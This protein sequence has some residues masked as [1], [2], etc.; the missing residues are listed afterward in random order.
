MYN[1]NQ[2]NLN[3]FNFPASD[4]NTRST[5]NPF[6]PDT[7]PTREM[8]IRV[9]NPEISSNMRQIFTFS[10]ANMF[11][12][13]LS[14][15]NT[16]Q[17]AVNPVPGT[18]DVYYFNANQGLKI[19]N[20]LN[21]P[22]VEIYGTVNT[23]LSQTNKEL[24]DIFDPI[25]SVLRTILPEN[26]TVLLYKYLKTEIQ[27]AFVNLIDTEYEAWIN[28]LNQTSFKASYTY[29]F[30]F[31]FS[32]PLTSETLIS[33]PVGLT[34]E[35]TSQGAQKDKTL[36][37]SPLSYVDCNVRIQALAISQEIIETDGLPLSV[38]SALT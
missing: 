11:A 26:T 25:V 24:R 14:I 23:T 19:V 5:N 31:I 6:L 33:M 35:L 36:V 7:D 13:G 27:N 2:V 10:D 16:F 28:F 9:E 29:N 34:I 1:R 12:Q 8:T 15:A 21:D 20:E 38:L 37:L 3:P 30:I 32:D 22:P 17:P 18:T 4:F